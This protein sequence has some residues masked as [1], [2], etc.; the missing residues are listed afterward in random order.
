MTSEAPYLVLVTGGN[1]R[2]PLQDPTT[3]GRLPEN[4]LALDDAG[5]SSRHAVIRT[6]EGRWILED[7]GSTNGT[8]LNDQRLEKPQ[9]LSNGDRLQLGAQIM[10]VQG[11][12]ASCTKCGKALP[13]E[14]V[15]CPGCG[16]PA[17][18]TTPSPTMVMPPPGPS[19][20]VVMTPPALAPR[21]PPPQPPPVPPPPMP[22]A[23]PM[24]ATPL[25]P[26]LLA[27][28]APLPAAAK[29]PLE[30]K[31]KKKGCWLSCCLV[32]LVLL[33]LAGVAGWFLWNRFFGKGSS[34]ALGQALEFR[35]V[36]RFDTPRAV[37]DWADPKVQRRFQE[38]DEGLWPAVNPGL[39]WAFF[40]ETSIVD[41]G[42]SSRNHLPVLFYNPW[43]DVA[44]VTVWSQE[45]KMSDA[46]IISGDCLRQSG[47]TPV[48]GGRG[49]LVQGSYGP[50]A[51]G[52]LTARTL[53]AFEKVFRDESS[54]PEDLRD[55]YPVWKDPA[56]QEASTLACG[57]QFAQ[58][59]QDLSQFSRGAARAAY[60]D[61][62]K[63][64]A[65]GQAEVLTALAS[66]TTPES[67]AFLKALPSE[68]WPAFKVTSFANLGDR[69]LIMAHHSEV[70][71]LFLGVVLLRDGGGFAP[72]RIDC[73]S[74]NACYNATRRGD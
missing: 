40:F 17:K 37:S 29:A 10:R 5:C 8:W 68:R 16:L 22:P 19:R 42:T 64:G 62:L 7:L 4:S 48:G 39:G 21:V 24:P 43:A 45:G 63:Q 6:A 33:I 12:G 55:A 14:A 69:A 2:F 66:A 11:L 27:P 32:S 13:A 52:G 31:P 50:A 59:F 1:K 35:Q 74:F 72:E 73:L 18:R 47:E 36:A 38:L 25:P 41:P 67:A 44:L 49:W 3:L 56:T 53:L 70:P 54:T 9:P 51:V 23:I 61:I 26:A 20:T 15:F 28:M 71:D 58:V 65:G 57:L 34:P 30:K 46:Q 60:V